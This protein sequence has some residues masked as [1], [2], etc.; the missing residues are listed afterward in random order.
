MG[1]IYQ[2]YS[3]LLYWLKKVGKHSLQSPFLFSLYENVFLPAAKKKSSDPLDDFRS[4]LLRNQTPIQTITLG[5]AS[6]TGK[7][8]YRTISQLVRTG[9]TPP[10][11]GRLLEELI[12]YFRCRNIYELGTSLGMTTLYLSR[13][14]HTS[15]ITFEGNPDLVVQAKKHFREQ[16]RQNIL[17]IEG[18]IDETLPVVLETGTLPDFVYI[19]ANHQYVPTINYFELLSGKNSTNLICVFD[20]IHWSREMTQAWQEIIRKEEVTLSIDLYSLGI[21][22]LKKEVPPGHIILDW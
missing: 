3:Y 19:D 22:F 1:V 11:S 15:V 2:A 5:A 17:L 18:N 4:T 20:D 6:R 14:S 10:R 13:P 12:V 8:M 21:V 16:G 7:K 9:S